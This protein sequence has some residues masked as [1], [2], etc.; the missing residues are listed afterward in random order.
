MTGRWR[1]W[2]DETHSDN[3]ELLR[4]FAGSFFDS[5][6]LSVPGEWA[7]VAAGIFAALVSIG[8]VAFTTF[9][10]LFNSM[11]GHLT[12]PEI[13]SQIRANEFVFIGLA[14][15]AAALFTALQWQSLFPAKRDCLALAGLPV[16]A[17]QIFFAKFAALALI[18]AVFVLAMNLPWAV[19]YAM[20]TAGHWENDPSSF[21]VIAANFAAT[22][23]ICVFV[24]FSLLALQ[25]ILLNILPG[26]RFG[27]ASL[28]VQSAVL[29][30]TLGAL[31]L[32][33]R[34]P[35]AGWWPSVWFVRLWESMIQGPASASRDALLAMT[36]SAAL[37]FL[38]YL[39][40]Y[41]RYRRLLLEGQTGRPA[42]P[43]PSGPGVRWGARLLDLWMPDPRQQTAFAFIW[44]TLLRSRTHRL[45]LLAYGGIALGAIT[46]GALDMPRP[47]LRDE[48]LYGLIVALA[49]VALSLL[50]TLG[51][52][53]LFALPESI[54]ANWLFQTT[55]RDASAAWLAAVERF[56]VWC[57]I[58]PLFVAT[59]PAAVAI[60][61]WTR[62]FAAMLLGFCAALV[63]FEAMF[64]EWRKLPFTCSYLPGRQPAWAILLRYAFAAMLVA[65][66][67][68]LILSCSDDPMGFLALFTFEA[69]LWYRWRARRRRMWA[70]CRLT[71]DELPDEA[72]M[73]L[74]LRQPSEPVPASN[75]EAAV[76]E[77]AFEP[78]LLAPRLLPDAWRD[79]IREERRHPSVVLETLWEDVRFGCRL[80]RRNPLFATV[81]ILTLTIGIG[82]NAS[83][84]TVFNSVALRPHVSS[85]PETFLRIAA[86]ARWQGTTRPVSYDEYVNL[87]ENA[88]TV[89]LLT[90]FRYYP[91]V[92][93]DTTLSE[94]AG[95]VVSCNFFALEGL[96]RPLLGRLFVPN[97]CAA[98]G[99]M[100]VTVISESLWRTRFGADPNV[101]GRLMRI[102]NRPALLVGVVS[103][104]ASRWVETLSLDVWLPYTAIPYFEPSNDPFHRDDLLMFGLAGRLAPGFSRSEAEAEFET[105][106]RRRDRDYPGRHTSVAVTDGS[107][108][109]E[110]QLRAS[111]RDVML[112]AFFF[113][114]FNLVLLIS[115]ANVAT[116]LLSRASARR[117][118]IAVRLSLGAPRIRLVRMLVTESLLLAAAAGAL[119]VFVARHVPLPLFEYLAS[120]RPDFPIE[121]D[122]RTFAY[123]AAVMLATGILAGLA[124][125]L[126]SLRV[127]LTATLK[128]QAGIFG[129]GAGLR[130]LLVSA[131]VA[132]SMVL[133]VEAA[134]FA[135]SEQQAMYADP[136]YNP[137]QVVV[138]WVNLPLDTQPDA[139]RARLDKIVRHVRA[140]PGVQSVAFSDD[141][142]LFRPS[143]VE[144]SPPFRGDASQ[145]VDIYTASPGFFATLGIPLL[146]G[147]EFRE[148]DGSAVVVSENLARA[149]W[150]RADPVGRT[151]ALPE[152]PV[153]I[154]GVARDISSTRLGGSDNPPVY[155]LRQDDR[156]FNAMSV[157]FTRNAAAGA[158]AIG[159][160]L[161]DSDPDLV[162][163]PTVLQDWI[164]RVTQNLWNV[165]S[166]IVVLGFVATVLA[167][168][169]IYGAV[170]FAVSQRTRDLGIRV[171]LGATRGHIVRDVFLSSGKPVVHGL[172]AGMWLAVPTAA[173]LRESVSGSP[174]H[175]ESSEPLL[176]CAAAMLL[177][178][179]AALA[180]L[181][182]AFRGANA[183]PL[184]ALRG[185]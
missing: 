28:A 89:R 13:F 25:G 142:P 148:D 65:P 49:P 135:R 161:R 21:T 30:F 111:A 156:R 103:D 134:L 66:A 62:A 181:G 53:Y 183:D 50:V 59:L 90:A 108:Y 170:S 120:R 91:A 150:H 85:H 139:A 125:A 78:T 143:T 46:K 38:A 129:G 42:G 33:N 72:I 137:R 164:D 76:I 180:M 144:L 140:L 123:I 74:G 9:Y 20:T 178:G 99:Q 40:S 70:E 55:D 7:K 44:K 45:I 102:N 168:T 61:G 116:L 185:D 3:F 118:E 169:G 48:G 133:L 157:R 67:G 117:R 11:E 58:A 145:P 35:V 37:A 43:V 6:M 179:A 96:N 105:L 22:G 106:E 29:I 115:C 18:F 153:T 174:I 171:A 182:P 109:Q 147:R 10:E 177:V 124:P 165:A 47:S 95:I 2:L 166:L 36:V 56:V 110:W 16:S 128:G 162:V 32:Y 57:G 132:L 84:F 130:S 12:R 138:S 26:R 176:Y 93:G 77:P 159:N 119:S 31:P 131:Q 114:T 100:P 5:E 4:H 97:D 152:G 15:G 167:A 64:R 104:G 126:E 160:T 8:F 83:V 136:G 149:F 73:S 163:V 39:L 54:R 69:A 151:L 158:A 122:W 17:R 19:E 154:V 81:V 68:Q 86:R 23:G 175:I 60:F 52:R 146:R 107:W 92:V 24:F 41:H 112:M 184:D 82:I 27:S 121:A 173:G 75:R 14:A 94:R 80:I 51:L 63:W 127:E 1:A 79:E 113:A 98:P 34:Q 101:I 141:L 155:R 172:I 71:Y 88:R 87:R